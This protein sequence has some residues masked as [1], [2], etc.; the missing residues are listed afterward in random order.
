M[1]LEALRAAALA[2]G[3]DREDEADQAELWGEKPEDSLADL[4]TS[5]KSRTPLGRCPS[6]F[7][8]RLLL[9]D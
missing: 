8:P 6:R 7:F 5:F 4:S 1:S 3:E 2:P 9:L